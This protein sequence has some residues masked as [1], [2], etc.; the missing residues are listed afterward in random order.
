MVY[1]AHWFQL[2]RLYSKLWRCTGQNPCSFEHYLVANVLFTLHVNRA[3]AR[4]V[5][6]KKTAWPGLK[7]SVTIDILYFSGNCSKQNIICSSRMGS[8]PQQRTYRKNQCLLKR[9]FRYGFA[10]KI[11]EVNSLL[12]SASKDLFCNMQMSYHCLYSLLPVETP[13]DHKL[14]ECGH[15]FVLS[16]CQKNIYKISFLN[17]CLF[18]VV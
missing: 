6:A 7:L 9:A 4:M 2:Y 10:T 17:K 5:F 14:R 16:R 15:K 8:F 1:T 12:D 3:S 11:L 18:S 13:H